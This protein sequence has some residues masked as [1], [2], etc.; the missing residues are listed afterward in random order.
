[1]LFGMDG[2]DD[3]CWLDAAE[4]PLPASRSFMALPVIVARKMILKTQRI[5]L[6]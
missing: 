2:A 1:M 4:N 3:D 5:P 6:E